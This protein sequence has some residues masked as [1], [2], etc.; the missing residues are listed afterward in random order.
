[1]PLLPVVAGHVFD[2]GVAEG[3]GG[4]P[5]GAA[6]TQDQRPA[7]PPA[8]LVQGCLDAGD[9]GV[10]ADQ[11]LTVAADEVDRP[12]PGPELVAPGE[13]GHHRELV[14]DGDVGPGAPREAE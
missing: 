10:A 3:D 1:A 7:A 11:P 8:D 14:G 9:V 6:P 13:P 5:G 12:D 2:L 4:S